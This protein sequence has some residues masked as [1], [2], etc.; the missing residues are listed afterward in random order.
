M[1]DRADIDADVMAMA[2][3]YAQAAAEKLT[4][5]G[6]KWLWFQIAEPVLIEA[7]QAAKDR[8]GWQRPAKT[9][10]V[11]LA[12]KGIKQREFAARIGT[13]PVVLNRIIT[14]RSRPGLKMI[15]RIE[16]ATEGEVGFHSWVSP[17]PS[18]PINH[19][20]P[21]GDAA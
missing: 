7:I 20:T 16:A 3:K 9:L 11:Y 14:G 21:D 12:E 15:H 2:R 8:H 19:E 1:A 18:P 13:S 6:D 10:K 4:T 17:L 5:P